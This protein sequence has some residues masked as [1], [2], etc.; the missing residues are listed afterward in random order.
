M[1]FI[2][3]FVCHHLGFFMSLLLR[4]DSKR[5]GQGLGKWNGETEAAGWTTWPPLS[6]RTHLPC[7]DIRWSIKQWL[8]TP[9]SRRERILKGH[10]WKADEYSSYWD[11][12]LRHLL[13]FRPFKNRYKLLRQRTQSLHR[14]SHSLP[15][16]LSLSPSVSLSPSPPLSL[17]H[18]PTCPCFF[19]QLCIF[20]FPSPKL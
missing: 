18:V 5:P 13:K 16:S 7:D 15:Q 6:T 17:E 19:P 10:T 8:V 9:P 4:Q 2:F 14:G 11:S 20:A 3:N 12:T 1:F